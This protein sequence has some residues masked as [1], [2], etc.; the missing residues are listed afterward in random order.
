MKALLC[1]AA[2]ALASLSLLAA[3]AGAADG[4]RVAK[5]AAAP[6]DA[7]GSPTLL[8]A[9]KRAF[10]TTI[11]KTSFS[12][13]CTYA[14]VDAEALALPAY[15]GHAPMIFVKPF[16]CRA[17]NLLARNGC[18]DSLRGRFDAGSAL[19]IMTTRA[20]ISAPSRERVTNR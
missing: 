14:A 4:R 18:P 19:I 3:G 2:A 6:T 5:A 10:E 20:S 17:L 13:D 9:V 11:A 16:V 1:V 12:L 7:N 8:H 15:K